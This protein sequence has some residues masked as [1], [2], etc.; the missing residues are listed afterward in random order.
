MENWWLYSPKITIQRAIE[1]N[2]EEDTEYD[3]DKCK[4][5][6]PQLYPYIR[7]MQLLN[8]SVLKKTPKLQK[9]TTLFAKHIERCLYS[10]NDPLGEKV[11]LV[12]QWVVAREYYIRDRVRNKF[13]T[14]LDAILITLHGLI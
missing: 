13:T 6:N 7:K 12:A 8:D 5:K 10:F 3:I 9:I 2:K 4:V 11:D 1:S 14:D